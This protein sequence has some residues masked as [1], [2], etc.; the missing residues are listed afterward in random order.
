MLYKPVL[1]LQFLIPHFVLEIE[2]IMK[3]LTFLSKWLYTLD[4]LANDFVIDNT[5][6]E[7]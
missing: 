7:S 4:L 3:S 5:F 1:V 2:L 6:A